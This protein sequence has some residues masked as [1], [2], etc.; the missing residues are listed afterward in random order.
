MRV[1]PTGDGHGGWNEVACPPFL[2][3]EGALP[4]WPFCSGVLPLLCQLCQEVPRAL[5]SDTRANSFPD[6]GLATTGGWER[7]FGTL[8][9]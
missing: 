4:D 1:G 2:P 8:V 7:G 3:A 6:L 5:L 9:L